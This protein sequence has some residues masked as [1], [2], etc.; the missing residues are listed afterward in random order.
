MGAE[1]FVLASALTL[2][3][4]QRLVRVLCVQCKEEAE[5]PDAARSRYDLADATV[6]A[7]GGC[8][9]CRDTG[10][11]GRIGT[12][13]IVPVTGGVEDCIYERCSTE[14][15]QRRSGRP[16]L[17]QDGLRKVRAGITSL[18]EVLKVASA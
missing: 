6:Y 12:F 4:A 2:V 17:L 8:A 7:A 5:L 15:I 18:E 1:P 9:Q 13:E 3:V 10:Y 14:E 11:R 16:T